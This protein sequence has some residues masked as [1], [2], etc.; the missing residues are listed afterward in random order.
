MG[1]A[2]ND[3]QLEEVGQAASLVVLELDV[4]GDRRQA[5]FVPGT[6]G[7]HALLGPPG[8]SN[9]PGDA[10]QVGD[11]VGFEGVVGGG[12][13]PNGHVDE[14]VGEDEDGPGCEALLP[15]NVGYGGGQVGGSGAAQDGKEGPLKDG[16]EGIPG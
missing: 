6:D 11:E 4:V 9:D 12:P 15:G 13:R 8:H 14:F 3:A 1:S 5:L 2:G 16:V 10:D 7:I